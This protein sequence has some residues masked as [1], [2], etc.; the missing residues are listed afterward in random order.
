MDLLRPIY[1]K[2]SNI[3]ISLNF[4]NI[5][6]A[7]LLLILG[8]AVF[9]YICLKQESNNL[10][11][12]SIILLVGLN[13]I[14][15]FIKKGYQQYL[16]LEPQKPPLF[17]LLVKMNVSLILWMIILP[18]IISIFSICIV[19]LY[20]YIL[21][22]INNKK[23]YNIL[24]NM[25]TPIGIIIIITALA[26]TIYGYDKYKNY[27]TSQL[28]RKSYIVTQISY[29]KKTLITNK[30]KKLKNI[31]TT[32][33]TVEEPTTDKSKIGKVYYTL[34]TCEPDKIKDLININKKSYNLDNK[35]VKHVY[36]QKYEKLD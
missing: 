15:V 7:V 31:S 14:T 16:N 11:T 32:T 18:I 21:D 28:T 26:S 4:F 2:M 25:T 27:L 6:S 33:T 34:E 19:Y 13:S 5:T 10:F 8:I 9:L 24:Y 17:E 12:I 20:L 30:G 36:V 35:L 29:D 1:E 22:L 3:G 23:I